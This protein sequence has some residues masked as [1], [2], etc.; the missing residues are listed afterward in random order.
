M[1]TDPTALLL[2]GFCPRILTRTHAVTTCCPYPLPLTHRRNQE[3]VAHSPVSR[4]NSLPHLLPAAGLDAGARSASSL[5]RNS[6]TQAVDTTPANGPSETTSGNNIALGGTTSTGTFPFGSLAWL[7]WADAP[8]PRSQSRGSSA[9]LPMGFTTK[10]S[11]TSSS[12]EPLTGSLTGPSTVLKGAPSSAWGSTLSPQATSFSLL[13][14]ETNNSQSDV[15]SLSSPSESFY[16]GPVRSPLGSATGMHR[17]QSVVGRRA[18]ILSSLAEGKAEKGPR[19]AAGSG[20]LE[21]D[22][23]GSD[24][25]G[26]VSEEAVEVAVM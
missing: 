6:L 16:S 7:A 8:Q 15:S 12:A 4:S 17:L 21:S 23:S 2:W 22:D 3:L 14:V 11:P 10:P 25:A 5:S 26:P 20:V 18:S 13:T 9:S 19:A 1:T 24:E